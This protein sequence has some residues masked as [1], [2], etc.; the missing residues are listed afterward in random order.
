M[1][2][3]KYILLTACFLL[4]QTLIVAQCDYLGQ[5]IAANTE[6]CVVLIQLN[7]GE[8]IEPINSD[9]Y[10][11]EVG[12]T[13]Q[14]DFENALGAAACSANT[15]IQLTCVE[16]AL[17]NP[18]CNFGLN[19]QVAG[20]TLTGTIFSYV[21]FG[22]YQPQV[23]TWINHSTGEVLSETADFTH[24]FSSVDEAEI[25]T[26]I[27]EVTYDD[28]TTCEGMICEHI[29]LGNLNNNCEAQF[30]YE[31]LEDDYVQLTNLSTGNFTETEWTIGEVAETGNELTHYYVT[32]DYYEVCLKVR[33]GS[34]CEAVYC[35]IIF[36]GTVEELCEIEECVYPG[37]ANKD[38]L[39]NYMDVLHI[40]LGYGLEGPA[41]AEDFIGS[42]WAPAPSLAWDMTTADGIDYKHLDTNGDG[43]INEDDLGSI[44]QNYMTGAVAASPTVQGHPNIWL[45]FVEDNITI[46]EDSPEQIEIFARVMIGEST[47]PIQ[48]LYG[49]A[50]QLSYPGQLVVPYS[51]EMTYD[52][53][54]FLGT[55]EDILAFSKDL[56]PLGWGLIDVAYSR[57]NQVHLSG[58]GQIAIAKF[59]INSD[60][61]GGRAEPEIDFSIGVDKVKMIDNQGIEKDI[62]V[63]A[64]P[65]TIK[66]FNT[67]QNSTNNPNKEE[68]VHIYPNPVQDILTIK[69]EYLEGEQLLI[70]NAMGQLIQTQ[71]LTEEVTELSVRDLPSGVYWVKVYTD[72]GAYSERLFVE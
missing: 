48:D 71:L 51:V 11:L 20:L 36:L 40:G 68:R 69:L 43:I 16:E 34:D 52:E 29:V 53:E 18:D 45:E 49:L 32:P 10:D 33:N 13:I 42:K 7:N 1:K 14:F 15:L 67:L 57:K 37:D 17:V 66:I 62:S 27:F 5:V 58:H 31:I 46:D 21:D 50:F 24:T 61:I 47:V 19:L 6:D 3:S 44:A 60:I 70:Y 56:G 26:A 22:P 54:A 65:A 28:G 39:S 2:K 35:E 59:I 8:V 64:A 72:K 12:E 41:R 55:G 38:G 4:M 63:P 25:I 30:S 9:I 23:V